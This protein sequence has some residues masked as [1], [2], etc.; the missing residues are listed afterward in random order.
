M[1]ML[2]LRKLRM[3]ECVATLRVQRNRLICYSFQLG[4]ICGVAL[5]KMPVSRSP[6][7]RGPADHC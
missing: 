6:M 1:I 7:A 2:N 4:L 5:T 3:N